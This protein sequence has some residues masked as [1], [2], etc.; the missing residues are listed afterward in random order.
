MGLHGPGQRLSQKAINRSHGLAIN[1]VEM[2]TCEAMVVQDF[3][4]VTVED[5]DTLAGEVVCQVWTRES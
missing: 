1:A 2:D 3:D 4:A 5:G